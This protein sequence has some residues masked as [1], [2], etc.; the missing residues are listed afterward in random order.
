[1]GKNQNE[2]LKAC[3]FLQLMAKQALYKQDSKMIR[4]IAR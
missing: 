4:E 3:W 1:M 2:V